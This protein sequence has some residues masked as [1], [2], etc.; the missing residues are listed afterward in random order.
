MDDIK[1][2]TMFNDIDPDILETLGRGLEGDEVPADILAEAGREALDKA[3][4]GADGSA[5]KRKS[6]KSYLTIAAAVAFLVMM[7]VVSVKFFMPISSGSNLAQNDQDQANSSDTEV[8]TPDKVIDLNAIATPKYPVET[9]YYSSNDEKSKACLD[10]KFVSSLQD[11]SS[12][13]S[14][15]VLSTEEPGSNQIFSPI[16]LYM[17]IA[18][19]AN[20]ASGETRSEILNTMSMGSFDMETINQQ[21]KQL[22]QNLYFDNE[23]GHLKLANSLWLDKK[24][25]FKQDFLQ[26]LAKDYY[27][28]SFNADFLDMEKTSEQI[29]EWIAEN[30]N[31]KLGQ[32]QNTQFKIDSKDIMAILNTVNFYDEWQSNFDTAKTAKGK[33]NLDNGASSECD[34]MNSTWDNL[35]LEGGQ[36]T[37]SGLRFKNGGEMT[38]ILPN[39]GVSPYDLIKDPNFITNTINDLHSYPAKGELAQVTFKVPKFTFDNHFS[40]EDVLKQLGIKKAFS[41]KDAEFSNI[42][43]LKQLFI[44][45]V[46]QAAYVSIDEKGCEAT[47]VSIVLPATGA[48]NPP[49]KKVN[50]ILDRPFIFVLTLDGGDP[51]DVPL[52][53]GIVNNPSNSK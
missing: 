11:F 44:S 50:M 22:F 24:V 37:A 14:S 31:G 47:A 38:F 34:F 2:L 7:V 39:Q 33:F 18:M 48:G 5:G 4:A 52:F 51:G 42:A 21:T 28:Y 29:N 35:V 27:A 12:R 32:N 20:G 19:T 25:P 1:L 46:E 9:S 36:F 49:E 26:G 13:L 41:P 3:A 6:W 17:A 30:T 45:K 8:P 43:D 53:V 16:S 40:L 15:A 10:K 23:I